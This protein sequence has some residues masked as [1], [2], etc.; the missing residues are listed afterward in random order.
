MKK[1]ISLLL[2]LLSSFF[3]S[4]QTALTNLNTSW[5]QVLGGKFISKPV[6][7]SF[8]FIGITDGKT[9]SALTN[10]GKIIWE[11][12]TSVNSETIVTVISSDFTLA[13][14]NGRKKITLYNPSGVPLWNKVLSFDV[15]HKAFEGRDG[16][17]F[18]RGENTLACYGINGICKWSIE[19]ERQSPVE[20][21]ELEDGSLIL[22]LKELSDGKTRALRITP[23]GKIIEDITFSGEILSSSTTDCGIFLTFS[24]GSAGLFGL[25][26]EKAVNRYVLDPRLFNKNKNNFFCSALHK[27][28]GVFVTENRSGVKL[29]Y[30]NGRNGEVKWTAILDQFSITDIVEAKLT[31][32]GFFICDMKTG[33]FYNKEGLLQ[34]TCSMPENKSRNKWKNAFFTENNTL[35]ICYD[36][37]TLNGYIVEQHT[38]NYK[39]DIKYNYYLDYLKIDSSVYGTVYQNELSS[40]ITGPHRIK[41]LEAGYYGEKEIL[42]TSD[43]ISCCQAYIQANSE[44]NFGVHDGPSLFQANVSQMESLLN[45][46]PYYGTRYTTNLTAKLLKK[47][48]NNSILNCIV[49]GITKSGYDPDGEIL[50][51]LEILSSKT[52]KS[53]IN[54]QLNICDAV[55][56]VCRFMG[57]PAFNKSGKTILKNFMYPSYNSKVRTKARQTMEMIAALEK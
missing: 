1:I 55:Y 27:D 45:Q 54:L 25:S 11:V 28:Y 38:G 50:Q 4:A 34:W 49:T 9:I 32:E 24:D 13:V 23:F 26:D 42:F 19:T 15:T 35:V 37:W 18:L 5:S 16:R 2:V 43:L 6:L 7:T 56:S 12:N 51:A 17:F 44:T 52:L 47:E 36:N 31:E 57:R 3:L 10:S 14:T 20:L 21:Q 22:F 33:Y 53:N 41:N 40:E 39:S 48:T 8:G 30:L 29:L 46:L